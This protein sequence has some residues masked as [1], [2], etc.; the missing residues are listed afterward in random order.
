MADL[1][2][3]AL[4]AGLFNPETYVASGNLVFASDQAPADLERILEIAIE[5]RFG[6][7]VDVIV[8]TASE[9]TRYIEANPFPEES[10]AAAKFVMLV[11]G[12]QPPDE[13]AVAS[14][15]KSA[16]AEEKVEAKGDALW[17]WFGNGAGRSKIGTGPRRGIW[18]SRNWRTV[19]ALGEMLSG[20][21]R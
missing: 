5:A 21:I 20:R 9:W 7:T 4:E 15:R 8:R 12:K 18:T 3:L 16:S 13:E 10:R 1:K 2:A 17:I 19:L 6:F 11:L 14:L